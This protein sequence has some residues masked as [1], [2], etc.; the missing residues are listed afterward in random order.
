MLSISMAIGVLLKTI[1]EEQSP[2]KIVKHKL[3]RD[4]ASKNV[5]PSTWELTHSKVMKPGVTVP[6]GCGRPQ[7]EGSKS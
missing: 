3:N 7:A 4:V 2:D 1:S 5:M 6:C